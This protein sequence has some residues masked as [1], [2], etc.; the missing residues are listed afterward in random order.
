MDGFRESNPVESPSME[1]FEALSAARQEKIDRVCDSYEAELRSGKPPDLQ[2]LLGEFE[3]ESEQRTLFAEL[4][5]VEQSAPTWSQARSEELC[6]AAPEFATMLRDL[7]ATFAPDASRSAAET[8]AGEDATPSFQRPSQQRHETRSLNQYE[9]LEE[10]GSGGFGSVW[11]ACDG[12]LQRTVAIKRPRVSGKSTEQFLREARLAAKLKHPNIVR[13]FEVGTDESDAFIVS[14]FID[15]QTLSEWISK[16][17]RP[18]NQLIQICA[19]VADALHHAHEN[20][21]VHRD[22][23]PTNILVDEHAHPFITDFGLAKDL[24]DETMTVAGSLLGS[25]AYMSPEQARGDA[26]QADRR[27]DVYSLGVLLYE[28]IAAERPFRGSAEAV[29]HQVIHL[30]PAALRT[31]DP[32]VP[33][34][35]ETICMKCLSKEPDQR[36]QTARLLADDLRRYDRGEPVHARPVSR[37]ARAVRWARRNPALAISSFVAVGLLLLMAI[38]GPWLAAVREKEKREAT[39]QSSINALTNISTKFMRNGARVALP[40]IKQELAH[41]DPEI[42][43]GFPFRHL[44]Y[45]ATHIGQRIHQT[46][47]EVLAVSPTDEFI[48]FGRD[49]KITVIWD[50]DRQQELRRI[51]VHGTAS[52]SPDG[53]QLA[54]GGDGRIRI[55]DVN[56]GTLVRE[57]ELN[58]WIERRGFSDDDALIRISRLTW[59]FDGRWIAYTNWANPHLRF[60][61]LESGETRVPSEGQNH[62]NQRIVSLAFAPHRNQLASAGFDG[63]IRLWEVDETDIRETH[64]FT[65]LKEWGRE[66]CY[67][68][69]GALLAYTDDENIVVLSTND[70]DIYAMMSF[71]GAFSLAF[72]PD[73]QHLACGSWTNLVR[74]WNV[75][76]RMENYVLRGHNSIVRST[77]FTHGGR[78]LSRD[79]SNDDVIEWGEIDQFSNALTRHEEETKSVSISAKQNLVAAVGDDALVTVTELETRQRVGEFSVP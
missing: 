24:A 69:N 45:V 39:R 43:Q 23:K 75:D 51:D 79:T 61:D 53:T 25:P 57:Y 54:I 62:E 30:D 13:V 48:V 59:S 7:G 55:F 50:L 71:P 8:D 65:V 22:L 21:I 64:T 4:I 27:S 34:D 16:A 40:L 2:S 56:T 17:P 47:M 28:F 77:V 5:R 42:V 76:K 67:S 31:L 60:L 63:R 9:L 32:T 18:R 44:H 68:H 74:V 12:R 36:Y 20:G 26:H 38:R 58:A 6:D 19:T 3:N 46:S 41:G 70:M 1:E 11:K 33:R 14:E 52:F 49:K 15:G 73:D 37:S 35:L 78:L 10:L 72:S 66:V 29:I